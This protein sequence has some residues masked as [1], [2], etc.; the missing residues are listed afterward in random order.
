MEKIK[1]NRLVLIALIGLF[2]LLGCK[3]CVTPQMEFDKM[4][5]PAVFIGP[6]EVITYSYIFKNTSG[7][8]IKF[9]IIDDKLGAVPCDVSELIPGAVATC[10]LT[11]TTTE[12]DVAAGII[13]NTAS[14]TGAF[15]KQDT[16]Y[17]TFDETVMTDSAE[18]VYELQCKLD[19]KKSANP[20]MYTM[21]GQ[22]IEY[23][24]TL[25]SINAMEL[26]GPFA[27]ADDRVDEWSCDDGGGTL[28]L[29]AGCAPIICRGSYT[30]KDAD[31]GSNITNTAHA[32]GVCSLNDKNVVSNTASATVYYLA[33]TPTSQAI[34][35]QLTLTET[36]DPTDYS[37]KAGVLIIYNYKVKNTGQ[38][39]VQ[40][41]FKVVDNKADQWQCDTKD[42]LP[43]GGELNC[44][45]YYQMRYSDVGAD[46]TNTAHVEGVYLGGAV[47]S[48]SASA[49]VYYIAGNKP[50][51]VAEPPPSILPPIIICDGPC[52]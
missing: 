41:P 42:V 28:A 40:G 52:P 21:S 32:E 35:P 18:V 51:P 8:A 47:I 26:H 30:V 39:D 20:T 4:A 14:A 49:T 2:V 11:Y 3:S 10:Q 15:V 27:I 36:V 6:G 50:P 5:E 24:Y 31:V 23:S 16:G 44:K 22:V 9:N 12:E 17:F 45:G 19:L 13:Q 48:N 25:S 7:T 46:I 1:R 34:Q 33:A 43:V 37:K 29:C 38:V